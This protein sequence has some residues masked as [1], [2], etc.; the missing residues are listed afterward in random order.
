MLELLRRV[1]RFAWIPAVAV[2]VIATEVVVIRYCTWY[3]AVDQYGYLTFAHD[4]L[5]GRIFHAWRPLDY[6]GPKF[7]SRT[8]ALAQTYVYDHGRLYCR[9]SPGFPIILA[10]TMAVFGTDATHYVNTVIYPLLLLLALA[11]QRR[12]F[13]SRWR[14]LVGTALI[15]LFPTFMHLWAL[16]LVRDLAAHTA[17]LA[18]LYLLLPVGGRRLSPGRAAAACLALGYAVTIRPDAV[19]YLVPGGLMLAMRWW[20]TPCATDRWRRIG[21][22]AAGAALGLLLGLAPFLTYNWYIT[23][24]PLKATQAME[25]DGFFPSGGGQPASE[26][27]KVAYPSGA[28]QGGTLTPVQGG[29]LRFQNFAK[30]FPQVVRLVRSAY[31]DVLVGIALVGTVLA[32][33]RRP[34]LVLAAIPYVLSAL[35]F[36]GFW[37]KPDWRYLVGVFVFVPML[38]VEGVFGSLDFVRTL[39]RRRPDVAR[40][41]ALTAAGAAAIGSA[42]SPAPTGTLLPYVAAV[43]TGAFVVGLVGAAALPS[44]RIGG[45]LAVA[46]GLVLVGLAVWRADTSIPSRY[47]Q[48]REM[49]RARATMG[50]ILQPHAVVITTESVGRPAENID[51]YARDAYALYLTDLMRWGLTVGLASELLARGGL[52]PYLLIPYT[53]PDR[54]K[55]LAD[56]RER[57]DVQLVVDIAPDR[58]M[59]YFVAASFYPNG[60]RMMLYRLVLRGA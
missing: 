37:S 45:W 23:G 34:Y 28:W 41:V 20:K 2:L 10:A 18:G 27:A 43:M 9:Y 56:L 3:L 31:T 39:A 25:L 1:S 47:F 17:G 38:I 32:V 55:M 53:Q 8:D 44:R 59:D 40:L 26:G 50:A 58:A 24:N 19:L 6:L 5:A 49:V 42:L 22:S 60:V 13:G 7:L 52:A 51:Y 54:E 11:F 36:F 4:L 16:T 57:F 14:A 21:L 33:R 46:T 35:V 29:G 48:Y 30:I 12:A 15:V